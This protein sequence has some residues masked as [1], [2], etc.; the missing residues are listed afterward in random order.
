[1][2]ELR[3][4]VQSM[5]VADE[6]GGGDWFDLDVSGGGEIV[7]GDGD[8]DGDVRDLL[9]S[10]YLSGGGESIFLDASSMLMLSDAVGGGFSFLP[11]DSAACWSIFFA[12]QQN[13][14]GNE[15]RGKER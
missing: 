14:S 9:G 10:W 11:R 13:K 6:D 5:A 4:S 2:G 8:G 1:M 7:E 15:M 12:R 3:S